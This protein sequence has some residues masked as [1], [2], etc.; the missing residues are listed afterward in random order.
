M[1]LTLYQA[2]WCPY[3]HR[4][5]QVLS[6]LEL[7]Y[8]NV[9]VP[10]ALADREAVR[11]VSGQDIV[12]VLVDGDR[13]L[14]ESEDIVDYL[15]A[16]YPA[17]GDADDHEEQGRFRLM[18]EVAAA[19]PVV[20]GALRAAFAANDIVVVSESRGPD[21]GV[22]DLN[23]DYALLQA[24]V[25]GAVVEALGTDPTVPAALTFRLAIFPTE[26]G[27]A[28][29]STRPS[30]EVWVYAKPELS[31][32]GVAVNQLFYKALDELEI[33]SPGSQG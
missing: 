16:T 23:E 27:T 8:T 28:I 22:P 13:V 18:L 4:V 7:T 29:V 21:L 3:C 6:E 24:T 9:N 25:P 31:R 15:R 17:P 1:A 5:R 32:L 12:P 26:S 2:E 19:P 11:E 10:V 14:I 30:A 33:P 20:L